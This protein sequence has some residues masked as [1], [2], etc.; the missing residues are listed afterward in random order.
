M[1]R[2]EIGPKF[3]LTLNL[4][5]GSIHSFSTKPAIWLHTKNCYA[6]NFMLHV[7]DM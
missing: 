7:L 6:Q 5:I 1:N 2:C 3:G 4:R